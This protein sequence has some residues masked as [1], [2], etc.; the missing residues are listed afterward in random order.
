MGEVLGKETRESS[1][2]LEF[3]EDCKRMSAKTSSSLLCEP[4]DPR[5]GSEALAYSCFMR[6]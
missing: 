4:L 5:E 2:A 1:L 3:H 6:S